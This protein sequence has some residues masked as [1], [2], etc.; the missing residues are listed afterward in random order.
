[1]GRYEI[2]WLGRVERHHWQHAGQRAR[3]ERRARVAGGGLFVVCQGHPVVHGGPVVADVP[4]VHAQRHFA[5]R[6]R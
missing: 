4:V 6:I 3:R 5:A 2:G 1:D